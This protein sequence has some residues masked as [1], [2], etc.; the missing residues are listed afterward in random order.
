MSWCVWPLPTVASCQFW[1]Q[2]TSWR[3]DRMSWLHTDTECEERVRIPFRQ[4][5]QYLCSIV[6]VRPGVFGQYQLLPQVLKAT[7][8]CF[9]C[10]ATPKQ[11]RKDPFVMNLTNQLLLTKTSNG[12]LFIIILF[13]HFQ[14]IFW[15]QIALHIARQ[16]TYSNWTLALSQKKN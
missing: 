6:L 7:N 16:I 2:Q 3:K 11:A 13:V 14:N 4:N 1:K 12:L 8:G 9:L 5:L 10:S 15:R